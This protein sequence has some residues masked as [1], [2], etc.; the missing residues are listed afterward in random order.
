MDLNV[1]FKITYGLYVVGAASGSKM[2]GYISNTVFQVTS[3]P[4]QFAV[5]SHK[6]NYTTEIIK[7]GKAFAISILRQDYDPDII[8]TFGYRS[9]R[10][11]E[12]FANFTYK[13]G[14]TGAPV[15]LKDTAGWL[16]CEVVNS[17]DLGTHILFIGNLVDC[18]S[19]DDAVE[20]LTYNYYHAVKKGIAPRNSPTYIDPRKLKTFP[21]KV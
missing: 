18:E 14:K 8:G 11:M 20:P 4:P 12:K 16:E 3:D 13:T 21:P 6:N 7:E 9:G 19:I 15:L 1:L 2:N 10:D 5:A 17:F